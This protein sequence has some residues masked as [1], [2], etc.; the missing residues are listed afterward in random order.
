MSVIGIVGTF[1][2]T[3]T[4]PIVG[5]G[6]T[7]TMVYYL[8]EDKVVIFR[9]IYTNF[10]TTFSTKLKIMEIFNRIKNAEIQYASVGIDELSG[11]L[12][13]LGAKAQ[14][15]LFSEKIIG[16]LRKYD[17][18]LYYTTQRFKSVQ[19]RVRLLTNIILEPHKIHEDLS[20][21][22]EPTC[23]REHY[24]LVY[25]WEP[26]KEKPINCL[27]ASQVG[28]LYNTYEFIN[29]EI[30]IITEHDRETIKKELQRMKKDGEI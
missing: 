28:K 15:V 2:D 16:Q 6:K 19:N 21:C 8:H 20:A 27:I 13:S 29:D 9:D 17:I 5:N 14:N 24:I 23:K 18:N 26:F 10:Q 22:Y 30:N 11:I 3:I 12:N 4:T 25:S 7:N 1:N